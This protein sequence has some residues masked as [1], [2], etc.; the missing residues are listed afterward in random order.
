MFLKSLKLVFFIFL[1]ESVISGFGQSKTISHPVLVELFTSEG[2][3]NCPWAD[4]IM[5]TLQNEYH[6]L[7]LPV[8]FVGYHV[9]YWNYLGWKDRF[10]SFLYTERQKEYAKRFHL[11]SIYTPQVVINGNYE[12]VG[13]NLE[14]IK[15]HINNELQEEAD[16]NLKVIAEYDSNRKSIRIKYLIKEKHK[17]LDINFLLVEKEQSTKVLKGENAGELLSHIN[18]VKQREYFKLKNDSIYE[19]IIKDR[20]QIKNH[21]LLVFVQ[22]KGIKSINTAVE[23]DIIIPQ[24]NIQRLS[25]LK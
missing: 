8:Y 3:S 15:T 6:K 23:T 1:W 18:I 19:F 11:Q 14:L 21:K 2:C 10:S 7:G 25:K 5:T 22:E 4:K 9:D 16:S 13:S 12:T 20:I 17:N 24:K